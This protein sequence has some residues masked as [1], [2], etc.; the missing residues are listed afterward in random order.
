MNG[1]QF[2]KKDPVD[3]VWVIEGGTYRVDRC[4]RG[5]AL[6]RKQAMPQAD[7]C[8]MCPGTSLHGYSL[9]DAVYVG[10]ENATKD[11][12]CKPCPKPARSVTCKVMNEP[13][14]ISVFLAAALFPVRSFS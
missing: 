3:S 8:E 11:F 14:P 6:I 7:H 10:D 4:P 1:T 13:H 5:F 2:E 12:Y 9:E